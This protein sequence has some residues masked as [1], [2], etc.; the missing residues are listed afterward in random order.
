[1]RIICPI[2]GERDSREF[3]YKGDASA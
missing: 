1:M 3:T 2:C